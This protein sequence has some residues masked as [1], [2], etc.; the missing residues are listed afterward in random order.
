MPKPPVTVSATNPTRQS[1]AS[2]PVYS[3]SPPETP[4][5]I[6]SL[7]LRRSGPRVLHDGGPGG[8]G[9]GGGCGAGGS[10]G[11][12]GG[13]G[14]A[15]GGA[16]VMAPTLPIRRARH[17]QGT[18]PSDP[19]SSSGVIT[20]V[21]SR[22]CGATIDAVTTAEAPPRPPLVRPRTGRVLAGVA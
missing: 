11:G 4:P 5:M 22:C 2:I 12:L 18:P 8:G 1:S 14:A 20:R 3:A 7:R 15:G 16:D 21:G 13:G 6:L 9:G 10:C 17:H 19:G